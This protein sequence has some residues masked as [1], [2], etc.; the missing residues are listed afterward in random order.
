MKMPDKVEKLKRSPPLPK[1]EKKSGTGLGPD[2]NVLRSCS[3]YS[4]HDL[5]A[6]K[7]ILKSRGWRDHK[8][9]ER[10]GKLF[11][12]LCGLLNI[13]NH[14]V[15]WSCQEPEGGTMPDPS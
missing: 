3:M 9:Y 13:S 5:S 15:S 11:P 2:R 1:E 6:V 14:I 10:P 4:D 12:V 7:D 8:Q